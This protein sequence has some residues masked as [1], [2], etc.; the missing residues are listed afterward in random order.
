MNFGIFGHIKAIIIV[1][2]GIANILRKKPERVFFQ[3]KANHKPAKKPKITV[4]NASMIS[5]VGLTSPHYGNHKISGITAPNIANGA[6]KKG[7]WLL[8]SSQRPKGLN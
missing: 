5:I 7:V 8:L 6:A 3:R 2:R 1:L 4:G